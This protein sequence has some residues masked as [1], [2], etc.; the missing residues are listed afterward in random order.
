MKPY[1]A[2]KKISFYLIDKTQFIRVIHMMYIHKSLQ[3]IPANSLNKQGKNFHTCI[4]SIYAQY[5]LQPW[6]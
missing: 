6:L 4:C 2:Q 3:T 1:E 5:G